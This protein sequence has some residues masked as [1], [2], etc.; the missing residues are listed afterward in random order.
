MHPNLGSSFFGSHHLST[1]LGRPVKGNG[2]SCIQAADGNP[3]AVLALTNSI[4]ATPVL[5]V[6]GNAEDIGGVREFLEDYRNA[7]FDVFTF[8]Y[9]GY[10]ISGGR[11]SCS[12][13]YE[14]IESVYDYLLNRLKIDP[15]KLIVHGRSVGA[16]VAL[17]LV[18]R[19]RVGGVIVE[20]AF[21]TAF[22]ARTQIPL[23]P[24]DKWKRP[25]DSKPK[26]PGAGDSW[27][28]RHD[29]QAMA[30]REA[31]R[32]GS[33]SKVLLLDSGRGARRC[34][35]QERE[36]VSGE[37]QRVQDLC[38]KGRIEP[39]GIGGSAAGCPAAPP[40]VPDERD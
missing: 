33:I 36:R 12:H 28:N 40:T 27:A 1:A 25:R 34:A 18:T 30:G 35:G 38:D 15:A 24:F 39:I 4:S 21:L 32:V 10:G 37:D 3:L 6:H 29:D 16:A 9:R 22:R 19:C 31:V 11:P 20:S 23:S 2:V 17:H 13:A 5:Y 14:D 26:V 8:D 7:G